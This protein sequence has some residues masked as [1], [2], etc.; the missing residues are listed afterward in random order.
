MPSLRIIA[1]G[2]RRRQ[3]ERQLPEAEFLGRLGGNEL[4]RAFAD[5]DVFVHT[6]VHE[7]FC[8]TV[9][10]ALASGVPVVAPASGGPLDQVHHGSN[11]LLWRPDRPSDIRAHV[12]RLVADPQLR[13]AMGIAARRGV[14]RN[15]WTALGDQ[16]I[17]HYRA[18]TGQRALQ[19]DIDHKEAS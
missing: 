4:S 5:L 19:F 7:T 9:Q 1:D 18:V 2:H 10:E 8:Q 16:L 15:S 12:R 6:G 17:G 3:L 13:T 11:G 14:A